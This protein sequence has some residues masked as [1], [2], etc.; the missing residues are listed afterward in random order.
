MKKKIMLYCINNF[1]RKDNNMIIEKSNDI[2]TKPIPKWI[3]TEDIK[4]T[5]IRKYFKKGV[6]YEN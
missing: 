6:K 2:G 4:I 5:E 3:K 1:I